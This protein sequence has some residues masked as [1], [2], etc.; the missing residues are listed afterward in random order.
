[1]RQGWL[2]LRSRRII[3][4]FLAAAAVWGVHRIY[5]E[6]TMPPVFVYLIPEGFVGPV[7]VFFGQKEGV[8]PQ[9][10]SLGQAVSV[11]ENGVLKLRASPRELI[12]SASDEAR[13]ELHVMVAKDGSRRIMKMF[14]GPHPSEDGELF[15]EGYMDE[16]D[17]LH[18]YPVDYIN[19][20]QPPK[21]TKFHYFSAAQLEE[22]MIF[23]QT[24]C[25]HQGF[26][27]EVGKVAAGEMDAD[28]VGVP[29]CGKFLV[30]SPNQLL[31]GPHWLWKDT[32]RMYT[33]ID[34]FVADANELVK[35]KRQ[36]RPVA[37]GQP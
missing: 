3:A 22:R 28:A 24:G 6:V 32:E 18:K 2:A 37:A 9:P 13:S 36:L 17:Q 26:V 1:M 14:T 33:S 31:T 21:L 25:R 35:K 10:D 16:A 34:E 19:N 11:P 15:W 5:K 20:N 4:A 8:E 27:P 7:F 12:R 23:N 30:A 29:D